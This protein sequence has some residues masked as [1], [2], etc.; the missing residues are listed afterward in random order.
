MKKQIRMGVF[1]TNSSMTHSLTICTDNEYRKWQNGEVYWRRWDNN[2]ITI[3]EAKKEFELDSY[4]SD[5]DEFRHDV[6][7]LTCDE[8]DDYDYIPFETFGETYITP[9]GD[10]IHAFGYYGHD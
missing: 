5:F 10:I 2:F 3:E 6:G 9:S 8:F 4:G 1:E 7:I